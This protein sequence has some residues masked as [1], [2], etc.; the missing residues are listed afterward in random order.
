MWEKSNKDQATESSQE[1]G[2]EGR[3]WGKAELGPNGRS[4]RWSSRPQAVEIVL[5]SPQSWPQRQDTL[6]GLKAKEMDWREL[7]R[8]ILNP[9][10]KWNLNSQLLL[11]SVMSAT[12]QGSLAESM[13]NLK[14]PTIS[15]CCVKFPQYCTVSSYSLLLDPFLCW[16]CWNGW[17]WGAFH[18]LKP[19]KY[20][21]LRGIGFQSL[22]PGAIQQDEE[23]AGW[24]K[25]KKRERLNS[26]FLKVKEKKKS[27][28]WQA[29]NISQ[30]FQFS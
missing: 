6:D 28:S 1:A 26:T 7:C 16:N 20:L 19:M 13:Q 18:F 30:V 22:S 24:C 3:N 25:V 11:V 27:V 5:S 2:E 10:Q 23:L 21:Y 8:V 14:V 12:L 29:E 15:S 17:D 4:P 9:N